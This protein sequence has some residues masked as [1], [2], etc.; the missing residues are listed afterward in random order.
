M[1]NNIH[2]KSNFSIKGV[3]LLELM[4]VISIT[5]LGVVMAISQYQKTILHRNIA[6]MQNSVRILISALEQ[7]YYGNCYNLLS[8][9]Q[10]S[11]VAVSTLSPYVA[12]PKII[13][14]PYIAAVGLA[15]YQYTIDTTGDFPILQVSTTFTKGMSKDILSTLAG[16][17]KPTSTSGYTFIWSAGPGNTQLTPAELNPALSYV[18]TL[19]A[20]LSSPDATKYADTC[21]YWQNPKNRCTITGDNTKCSYPPS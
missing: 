17:L 9:Y 8:K 19:S 12:T 14:N 15:N 10:N 7:Y 20:N 13:G 6:Q 2:L 4:L 16:A 18:N 21:A 5:L 11:T 1:T 3:T